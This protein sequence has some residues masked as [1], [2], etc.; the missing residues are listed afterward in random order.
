MDFL[1]KAFGGGFER[2]R[3][4]QNYAADISADYSDRT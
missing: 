4:V 3:A 1:E 2:A